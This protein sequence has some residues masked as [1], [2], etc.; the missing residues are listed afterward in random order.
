M[1]TW[2]NDRATPLLWAVDGK[3]YSP[4]GLVRLLWRL[5]EWKD[6]PVAV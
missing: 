6:A 5:A 4:S 1:A 2:I 3:Q